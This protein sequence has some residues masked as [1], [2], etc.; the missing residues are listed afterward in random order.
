MAVYLI[1]F[2]LLALFGFLDIFKIK[3]NQKKAIIFAIFILF[4]LLDGLR[5]ETGTDWIL[6]RDYFLNSSKEKWMAFEPGYVLFNQVIHLFSDNYT[7]FLIFLAFLI[8]SLYLKSITS[9]AL[10]PLITCLLFYCAFVGYMGM[11]RQHVA[12]A[13]CLYSFRYVIS[14]EFWKFSLCVLLAALFH[15]TASIFFVVYFL[16]RSIPARIFLLSLIVVYLLNPVI[17]GLVKPLISVMPSTIAFKLSEYLKSDDSNSTLSTIMGT[18]KRAMI[19]LPLYFYKDKIKVKYPGIELMLNIYFL[20]LLI[21]VLF[22]N[23]VQVFVSRGNLYFGTLFEIFLIPYFFILVK[24]NYSRVIMY[25]LII[26]FSLMTLIKSLSVLYT[27]FVP[28]KGIIINSDY[29]RILF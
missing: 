15:R 6:Y 22:N 12:L 25:G 26:V 23:S 17:A 2:L 1:I 16:N 4:V 18:M 20:S 28:Y 21:Y 24:N 27:L 11:N 13:I 14:K 7:V 10:Y 3:E 5:W 19:F 8:Y 29:S 9:I